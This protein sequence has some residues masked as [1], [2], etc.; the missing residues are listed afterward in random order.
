M[1]AI[2]VKDERSS[3][4]SVES[5]APREVLATKW[6]LL[7]INRRLSREA[8]LNLEDMALNADMILFIMLASFS[9]KFSACQI[10]FT[11]LLAY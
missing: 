9:A 4:E 7:R 6:L 3:N 2:L 5:M 1:L 11:G 10:W 8:K